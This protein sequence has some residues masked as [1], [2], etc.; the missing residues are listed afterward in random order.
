MKCDSLAD[1]FYLASLGAVSLVGIGV[2]HSSFG[3]DLGS[4]VQPAYLLIGAAW[5]V[6]LGR[7]ATVAGRDEFRSLVAGT[8]RAWFLW[9]GLAGC[10]VGVSLFGLRTAPAPIVGYEALPRF[11]KQIL[12]LAI[13]ATFT[14]YAAWWTRGPRRWRLTAY[15]LAVAVAVQV[16]YAP[17]Q[18]LAVLGRA[19]WVEAMERVATSNPS[20]LSG[21]DML[22]LGSYTTIPRLRGSMC[23]P[24]YLGS[25]L[26]GFL[27]ILWVQRRRVLAVCALVLLMA[28]WSRSAW[29]ASAATAM[30]WFALRSRA[31]LPIRWTRGCWYVAGGFAAVLLT[32]AIAAPSAVSLPWRRAIQTLDGTDWSNLTRVYSTQAAWRAFLLSPVVGVGWG[33]FPFHFYALVDLAG[34]HSQFT[35]PV[36]NSVPLLVLCETGLVGFAVA[37]GMV[38]GGWRRTWRLLPTL[39]QPA[40]TRLGAV[41]AAAFG[42]GVHL[43]LFSQYNLPHMWVVLGLWLAAQADIERSRSSVKEGR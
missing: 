43:L 30:A 34:L 38:A 11:G 29:F 5:L 20:I 32:V 35:W 4:G 23:E 7:L 17:L 16:V 15:A 2:V 25:L 41:S 19:P 1:T 37:C 14:L 27:P 6:R 8:P 31:G 39:S 42:V 18:G 33:Q 22:Y 9:A 3:R 24:L 36:V 12:Q 21:S 10:A 40:A 26:V 28:T 13:M